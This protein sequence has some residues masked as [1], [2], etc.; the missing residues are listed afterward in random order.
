MRKDV[1]WVAGGV[2]ND[3]IQSLMSSDCFKLRG[4]WDQV[5]QANEAGGLYLSEVF[6][7]SPASLLTYSV[8]PMFLLNR[9]STNAAANASAISELKIGSFNVRRLC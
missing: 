4:I 2:S 8:K 1:A 7:S 5:F 3:W 9:A 6:G